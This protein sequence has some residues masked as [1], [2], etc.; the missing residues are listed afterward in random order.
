MH[1]Q[2]VVVLA[3]WR[4]PMPSRQS[5]KSTRIWSMSLRS[6]ARTSGPL[7]PAA[8]GK[9]S[10]SYTFIN[11]IKKVPPSDS[12]AACNTPVNWSASHSLRRRSSSAVR[13]EVNAPV[14]RNLLPCLNIHTHMWKINAHTLKFVDLWKESK[15]WTLAT[16]FCHYYLKHRWDTTPHGNITKNIKQQN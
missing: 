12:N 16:G 10:F 11:K 3:A 6:L 2:A 14:P 5:R 7:M 13:I 4:R 9:R 8:R 1:V 15:Y